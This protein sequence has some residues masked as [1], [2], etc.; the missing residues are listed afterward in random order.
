M[1]Y[2]SVMF[3]LL[4]LAVLLPFGQDAHRRPAASSQ[5]S[6]QELGRLLAG[7]RANGTNVVVALPT[8]PS[9]QYEVPDALVATVGE[10]DMTFLDDRFIPALPPDLIPDGLHLADKGKAI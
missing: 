5:P 9:R 4:F 8:A 2:N 3:W 10:A 1:N 7:A 6:F